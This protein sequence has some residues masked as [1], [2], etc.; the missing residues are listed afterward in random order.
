MMTQVYPFHEILS[1]DG[2]SPPSH[3]P[4]YRTKPRLGGSVVEL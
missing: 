1:M 4:W 3:P 2:L